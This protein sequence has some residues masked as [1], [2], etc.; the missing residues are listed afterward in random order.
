MRKLRRKTKT[1]CPSSVCGE[2]SPSAQMFL[3]APTSVFVAQNQSKDDESD[4]RAAT[5]LVISSASAA[6]R[7]K[8]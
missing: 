2:C 5:S 7:E 8:P 6:K 1:L 4:V 3:S